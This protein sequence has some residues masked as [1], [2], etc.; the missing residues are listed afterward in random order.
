[1]T[2]STETSADGMLTPTLTWETSAANCIA[3]GDAEWEGPKA[4]AGTQ[5]LSP[6]P[7]TQPRAFAL[8]CS[9]AEDSQALLT[10][11]P[12][13][14]NTDGT[15]LTNLAG[16]RLYYGTASSALTETVQIANPALST[17]V[18][19]GLSPG[20]W[21]FGLRA[22]TSQGA[23]SALSNIVTKTARA[24]IEWSQQAGV[25]VPQAPALASAE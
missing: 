1:M 6:A 4:S 21:Y 14:Q 20:P 15:T 10:W 17:Y 24:G 7:T 11:I 25:K 2:L 12:P 9:T 18:V 13:T 23:E 19:D 8:I 16:Y 22:Y 3:S 5:T